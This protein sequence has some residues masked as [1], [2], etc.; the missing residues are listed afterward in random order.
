MRRRGFLSALAGLA[1]LPKLPARGL[2][3][4]VTTSLTGGGPACLTEAMMA[5]LAAELKRTYDTEV[6]FRVVSP[7]SPFRQR[8]RSQGEILQLP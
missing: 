3:Q 1:L 4:Y 7:P 6:L 8:L 5:E 2:D